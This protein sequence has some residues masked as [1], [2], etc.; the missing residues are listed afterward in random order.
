VQR[1]VVA[2]QGNGAGFGSGVI[3]N[4]EGLV[5]TNH[6]VA[7]RDDARIEAGDGVWRSARVVARSTHEDIAALQI[8]GDVP[9]T[10]TPAQKGDARAL[11]PGELVLAVGNPAGERNA[12][13]LGMAS[14]P[15]PGIENDGERDVIRAAITLRPGNSGGALVDVNGRVVGIP[16][17]VVGRGLGIA[18]PSHV[19]ERM[20]KR[21]NTASTPPLGVLGRWVE[22]PEPDRPGKRQALRL[23]LL[24]LEVAHGGRAA[25]A[26]ITMGD[27]IIAPHAGRAGAATLIAQV[28]A[29]RS[30]ES[31]VVHILRAGAPIQV[32][33]AAQRQSDP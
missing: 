23:G 12:V 4:A 17:M 6:H 25:R 26:G 32:D 19:V 30:G 13:T 7:P 3:W 28:E 33:L 9:A 2:I 29:A 21:A 31:V 11:R 1:S 20:L 5:V 10:A 24:V 8:I 18:V 22:V 16:N 14:G 15:A 27:V